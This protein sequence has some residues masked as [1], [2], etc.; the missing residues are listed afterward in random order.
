MAAA[1]RCGKQAA[2][3]KTGALQVARA[4]AEIHF[5]LAEIEV[6]GF[7]CER[8]VDP[9]ADEAF[10]AGGVRRAID[11]ADVEIAA[12]QAGAR[13]ADRAAGIHALGASQ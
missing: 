1:E 4:G 7:H 10:C 6:G 3:A 13:I 2:H 9:I 8:V 12:I 5:H 11:A